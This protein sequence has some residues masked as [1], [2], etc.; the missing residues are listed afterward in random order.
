MCVSHVHVH[1]CTHV[2]ANCVGMKLVSSLVDVANFVNSELDNTQVG[3]HTHTSRIHTPSHIT[4]T[5]THSHT[6]T[7][8]QVEA[9]RKRQL[10]R[11][12]EVGQA[13]LEKLVSKRG[14]LQRNKNELE[15]TMKG[16][17]SSVFVH[18][19]KDVR[20]EVRSV[21]IA[22]LGVWMMNYG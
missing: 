9:E 16:L 8:R 3:L 11:R 13:K 21:C 15:D 20:P 22:E 6:H 5:H 10:D 14:E 18:R 12:T 2:C 17:F 1:V 19:Y 4:H 7:Q